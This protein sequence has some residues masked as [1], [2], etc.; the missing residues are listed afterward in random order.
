MS[1]LSS[2]VEEA[3]LTGMRRK[4]IPSDIVP[5]DFFQ[6]LEAIRRLFGRLIRAPDPTRVAVIPS[7]S[8]GLATAA[9]NTTVAR[10]QNVVIVAQQFPSNV[11]AWRRRA[12]A[13]G[14]ELR[15]VEAPDVGPGRGEEWNCRLLEAI[16]NNTAA[17][18]LGQVHWT[19]GT[20]FDLELVGSRAR[21]VGAAL[22]V[23]GTQSVGALPFDVD[24]LKPD[25]LVCAGY[26]WLLGPYGIGLAYFGSR[27]DGGEPLEETWLARRGSEDFR[28]LVD[29]RDSYRSGAARYDAGEASNFILVPMLVAALE[30]LLE[31]RVSRIQRYCRTLTDALTGPMRSLGFGIEAEGWRA[32]HMI[33]LRMPKG[34]DPQVVQAGLASRGVQVSV[35]GDVLRVSPH[36]Y[37]DQSDIGALVGAVEEISQ[38]TSM[39]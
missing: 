31:W 11:Y 10:G 3:G 6:G 25:A 34:A 8:Y 36:V 2:R 7:A 18:A 15:T 4:R 20:L 17:V 29:Y 21:E 16:D 27:Y 12:V 32:G 24:R 39:A 33:G 13:A 22:I 14:A 1:P 30:Q 5:R 28:G 26:K 23:D 9:R 35:R 37:N 38:A 19:D